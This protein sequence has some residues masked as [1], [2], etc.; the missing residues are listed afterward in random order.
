M[1][2][3]PGLYDPK[4]EQTS[5][6]YAAKVVFIEL[7]KIITLVIMIIVLVRYFLFRPFDVQGASMEPNYVEDEYLIID[8]LSYRFSLPERGDVI[9]FR[10]QDKNKEFFLKR[11]VGLPNEKIKV[12]GGKVVVYNGIQPDGVVIDEDMYLPAS[13]FTDGELVVTLE[14][15]EYFVLGDNR[16]VSFDSR[17]F[18]PINRDSIVGRVWL[19]GW[20]V[21]KFGLFE[22]P[23]YNL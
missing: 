7:A 1:M 6:M 22:R 19:R 16:G 3:D 8:E 4:Q 14:G 12:Q 18:G 2:E 21:E 10:S 11:I 5:K 15:D 9:V 20:P 23:E 13:E 17:K